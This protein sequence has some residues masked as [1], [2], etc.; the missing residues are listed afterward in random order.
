MLF[1]P[2]STK[3]RV[4][5]LEVERGQSFTAM[6]LVI[7]PLLI[8]LFGIVYDL[9]NV[10]AGVSIAQNAADLAAQEAGKMVDVNRYMTYQDIRLRPEAAL[11]AQQVA[12]EMTEGAFVVDAVYI[13]GATIVV[14]GRV[15][16]R[17]P[18]LDTFLGRRTITRPVVGIAEAAYGIEQEGLGD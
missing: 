17:T 11:V 14:E 18:F 8:L 15:S 13:D 3:G 2:R 10:A 6:L 4:G 12:D 16:V 1:V 5:L 9:G 7:L